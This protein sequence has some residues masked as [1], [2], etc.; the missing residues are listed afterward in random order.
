LRGRGSAILIENDKVALI[1]RVS[2][3]SVYYVFPGGGIEVGETPEQ[4]AIREAFEELGVTITVSELFTTIEW[5]G[6][7]YFYLGKIEKGVFGT[8]AGEEF[9][10]ASRD[11]GTYEPMWVDIKDLNKL[12]IK[13]KEVADKIYSQFSN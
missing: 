11:R 7:Q 13:P 9:M 1:K 8:G 4:A 3:N 10:D 6:T 12:D 2:D 5:N